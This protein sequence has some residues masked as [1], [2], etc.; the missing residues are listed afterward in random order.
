[1]RGDKGPA[2]R[3]QLTLLGGVV[4]AVLVA[5]SFLLDPE[6]QSELERKIEQAQQRAA[7]GA[8]AESQAV[9][10]KSTSNTA[11]GEEAPFDYY[12]LALSWSPSFCEE[13]PDSD[14]CGKGLRFVMPLRKTTS[15]LSV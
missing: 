2:N 12:V 15:P 8:P 10:A 5:A 7:S 4:M 9:P 11:A 13:R 1:M 14:Q 3:G 6:A